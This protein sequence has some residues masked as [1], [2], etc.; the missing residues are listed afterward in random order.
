M[1]TLWL[2]TASDAMFSVAW[3]EASSAAL[4]RF[5]APSKKFTVAVGVPAAGATATTVAE[6]VMA[7]PDT[8]GLTD[9]MNAVAVDP[10]FTVRLVLPV[11]DPLVAVMV[12]PPVV[13]AVA[14][15]LASMLAAEALAELQITVAVMF[16]VLLSV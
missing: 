4:P 9:V 13:F 12:V 1:V 6:K 2:P 14:R 8:D 7:C 16:C 10:A 3:P 11:I 5:V 15:P